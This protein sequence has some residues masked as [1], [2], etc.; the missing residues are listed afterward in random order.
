MLR[1]YIPITFSILLISGLAY[2]QFADVT[3]VVTV[4]DWP[5]VGSQIIL[6]K[7]GVRVYLVA[8]R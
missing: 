6:T 8:V 5:L 4:E 2:A 7:D 1:K 3:G